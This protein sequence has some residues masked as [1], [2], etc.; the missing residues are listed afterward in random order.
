MKSLEQAIADGWGWAI[1][2]PISVVAINDF[3]NAVICDAEGRYFR[4]IPEDLACNFLTDDSDV[5]RCIIN[6]EEFQVDWDM[7]PLRRESEEAHGPLDTGQ[8]YH[9]VTPSVLGG[10][11]TVDNVRRI[12]IVDWLG[13]AGTIA[14][15]IQGM[16]DGSK[17]VIKSK[18]ECEQAASSNR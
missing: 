17:V 8:C 15:Q 3:G 6:S 18:S 16:P 10:S 12:S 14:K 7:Q 1:K 11:Y 2:E 9:L 4:I 5:L 13:G